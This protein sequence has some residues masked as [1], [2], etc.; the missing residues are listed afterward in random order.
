VAERWSEER[1]WAWHAAQPWR[2]G[3]NFIPSN[4]INQLE[5]WQAETFDPETIDR[6]LG[7]AAAIGMNAVRVYLHDL[8]W[9]DDAAGFLARV[10]RFL[11]IA[12]RHGI[13]TMLVLFDGVWDPFPRLGRQRAPRPRVHN[14]GWVQSP[15]V[16]VLSD[17][18]RHGELEGYV[19]GVA[20]RF[21]DDPRILL[22][23]VMNEPDNPNPV[24]YA[25]HEPKEKASFAL[26]LLE[27]AYGW[28]RAERVSQPLTSAVWQGDWRDPEKLTPLDRFLLGASD[29]SSFH[30]YLSAPQL[31]RRI[32]AL[33]PYGRPLVCSEFL[34]RSLGSTF[35]ECLPIFAE[36]RIGAF[37][38]GLVAGKTQTIY[39]WDSWVKRYEDEPEEWFHDVL[40]P[41][42]TPYR[43]EEVDVMRKLAESAR[44]G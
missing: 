44:R 25:A 2:F 28:L 23:D 40:R 17:P 22:W 43:R 14:S 7:W 6:E 30:C 39:S 35:E 4:A 3:C 34:A 36:K 1:A 9:R 16:E 15:G 38:W 5:M 24:S 41:D 18:A 37:C 33:A 20:K 26:V 42:G 10:D 19:R 31:R 11:A 32:E 29:V 12:D 13:A 27:R 21:R 8:L